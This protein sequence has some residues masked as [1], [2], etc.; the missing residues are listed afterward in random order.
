MN[1]YEIES[2]ERV[3]APGKIWDFILKLARCFSNCC[4]PLL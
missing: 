1:F 3:E 4:P 2:L